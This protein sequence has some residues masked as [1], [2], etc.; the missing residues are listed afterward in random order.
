M[1]CPW[2]LP[3]L[4]MTWKVGPA[5]AAGN[6]VVVEPSEETPRRRPCSRGHGRDRDASRGLQ[7]GARLWDGLRGP[8]AHATPRGGDAFTGGGATGQRIMADAAP[9]LKPLSFE[10]GGKNRRSSS[11]TPAL[12]PPSPGRC[13]PPSRTAGRSAC[14]RNASTWSAPSMGAS[15]QPSKKVQ[16]LRYGPPHGPIDR[17]RAT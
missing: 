9:T 3:L 15:S 5:L 2:N 4:L 6:T 8:G 7:R 16:R 11:P 17:D 10:L 13:A 14:A 12:T 1:I